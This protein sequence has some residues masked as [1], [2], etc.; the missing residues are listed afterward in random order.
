MLEI[1]VTK[2]IYNVT[3]ELPEQIQIKKSSVDK[4]IGLQF[5]ENFKDFYAEQ[6]KSLK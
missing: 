2:M 3:K 6:S 1:H 4:K 5:Y